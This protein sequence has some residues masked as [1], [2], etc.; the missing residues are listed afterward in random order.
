[1]HDSGLANTVTRDIKD[2]NNLFELASQAITSMKLLP[3]ILKVQFGLTSVKR[4]L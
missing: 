3:G 4:N 2:F 1:M